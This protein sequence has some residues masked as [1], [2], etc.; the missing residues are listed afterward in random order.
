MSETREVSDRVDASNSP[1]NM[2]VG[3]SAAAK[4]ARAFAAIAATN[5]ETVL[6]LG[7]TGVGKG[8]LANIIAHTSGKKPFVKADCGTLPESLVQAALFGH[9]RGAFTGAT[10]MSRGLVREADGGM[11]FVDEIGNLP[12]Q[13]QPVLLRLLEEGT[14][15]PVGGTVDVTVQTRFVT[16]TNADLEVRMKNGSFRSDLYYRMSVLPFEIPPLRDRREDVPHLIPTLLEKK[17]HRFT[18]A[19]I[20]ALCGDTWPG[21]VRELRN[22][23]RFQSRGQDHGAPSL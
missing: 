21:N 5:D 13:V 19:A 22:C 20:D 10:T 2:F 7:E 14:F 3:E 16:A 18:D 1:L 9:S 8:C 23:I 17:E 15:R 12:L 11:L 6:L 4:S